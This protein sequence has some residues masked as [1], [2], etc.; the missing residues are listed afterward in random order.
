ML[1]GNGVLEQ[2]G[3]SW[4]PYKALTPASCQIRVGD[5]YSG[6]IV[7][8]VQALTKNLVGYCIYNIH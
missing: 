3:R 5:E 4:H 6:S 2:V 1:G 7:S 8:P